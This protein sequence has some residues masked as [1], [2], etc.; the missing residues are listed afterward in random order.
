MVISEKWIKKVF[1]L[2]E[3]EKKDEAKEEVFK[4]RMRYY[5]KLERIEDKIFLDYRMAFH[6]YIDKNTDLANIYF[7]YLEEIYKD[8]YVMKSCEYDYY[9]YR[10]L[11]VNNNE[12]TLSDKEKIDEMIKIYNYYK[13]IERNDLAKASLE[14]IS[15]LK[16][17]QEEI[18]LN[19]ESLLNERKN[20]ENHL[21]LSILKDCEDI[22]HN[23]YIK[24]LNI[25]N[26]YNINMQAV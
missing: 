13:I 24:A 7:R 21:I 5:H 15:K 14:N 1:K 17:N 19:L 2:W 22:S 10:W 8:E 26:K 11:Y 25:V 4:F 20:Q 12:K 23:L 3:D 16:G 9:R 18:L 6:E